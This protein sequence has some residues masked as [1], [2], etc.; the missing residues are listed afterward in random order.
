MK[1]HGVHPS[2][3]RVSEALHIKLLGQGGLHMIRIAEQ[4][5]LEN[6]TRLLHS[7]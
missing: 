4:V 2:I 3:Q 7:L 6:G 1:L 5:E